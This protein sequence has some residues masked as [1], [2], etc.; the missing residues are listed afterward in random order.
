MQGKKW[1]YIMKS[2]IIIIGKAP[3][4]FS[5][6]KTSE[7]TTW[8]VDLEINPSIPSESSGARQQ[9]FIAFNFHTEQFEMKNLAADQPVYVNGKS[10]TH[11]DDPVPLE[12]NDMIQVNSEDFVFLLPKVDT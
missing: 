9:A 8:Q 6:A 3:P 11:F 12:T 5:K 2:L 10:Y 1:H 4:K 7:I